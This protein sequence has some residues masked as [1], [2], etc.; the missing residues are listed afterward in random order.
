M[1]WT[2]FV[3]W[4]TFTQTLGRQP[5][6]RPY[7]M[8]FNRLQRIF[9]TRGLKTA[10]WA[11]QGRD[12]KA[13]YMHRQKR[14]KTEGQGYHL[15]ILPHQLGASKQK[16]GY[17]MKFNNWLETRTA[18]LGLLDIACLKICVFAFALLLAKLWPP[19]LALDWTLYAGVF[20]LT[21]GLVMAKLLFTD[22][23]A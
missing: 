11:Q 15:C 1:A 5:T 22:G 3:K 9:R 16:K 13:I 8:R 18:R 7:P 20:G 2:H 21:Y 23:H 6:A 12:K 14:H 17:Q 10:P 4:M 19:L